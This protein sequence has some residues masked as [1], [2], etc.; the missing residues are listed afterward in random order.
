MR[1][2]GGCSEPD[3]GLGRGAG[4][5]HS[6]SEGPPPPQGL[7]DSWAPTQA[8]PPSVPHG[9]PRNG[10]DPPRGGL[11]GGEV[12]GGWASPRR[13]S[14]PARPAP[15][16]SEKHR[17]HPSP[18]CPASVSP[19]VS[20]IRQALIAR[21]LNRLWVG[22][23]TGRPPRRTASADVLHVSAERSPET[24][25]GFGRTRGA[26]V[27]SRPGSSQGHDAQRLFAVL[28]PPRS[29]VSFTSPSFESL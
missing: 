2:F 4:K 20:A 24:K 25:T 3:E 29:R 18:V 11:K 22:T 7:W 23:Q 12:S 21:R 28:V 26:S 10:R 19:R 13:S 14:A 5:G 6:G 27:H 1:V 9:A 8:G 16:D 15:P 17:R